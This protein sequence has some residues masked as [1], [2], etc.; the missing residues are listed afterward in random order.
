MNFWRKTFLWLLLVG[1]LSVCAHAQ[2]ASTIEG[3]VVGIADGDTITILDAAARPHY[4]HLNGIDSPE[5]RQEFGDEARL[6]LAKLVFGRYVT[7]E[8][9][10][11]DQFGRILGKVLLLTGQ[12]VNLEQIKDGMAWYDKEA[13]RDQTIAER[14]AYARAE[15]KARA[16]GNGLWADANPT[17][18]WQWRGSEIAR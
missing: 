17:P 8:Y 6:N 7:V 2:T 1:S 15:Q 16:K 11:R 14:K 4:V 12:D 13:E 5:S 3:K 9:S 10:K 18:P